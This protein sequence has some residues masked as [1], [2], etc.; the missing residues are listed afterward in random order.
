MQEARIAGYEYGSV[1]R[2]PATLDALR[3]LEAEARVDGWRK[4]IGSPVLEA[5]RL[6]REAKGVSGEE[7]DQLHAAWSK[8]V[9]LTLALWSRPYACTDLW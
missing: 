9:L 8:A 7:I 6:R 2:S 1:A 3:E 4:R 5:M